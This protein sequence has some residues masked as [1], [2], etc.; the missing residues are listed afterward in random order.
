MEF[1]GRLASFPIGDILQWAHHDRRSGALVVRRSGTE[2]R[3]YLR[4]GDI[5]ACYSDDAAEYFGQYLLVRGLLREGE[6]IQALTH[7]QRRGGLLGRVLVDVGLL[8][9]EVMRAALR[10][11]VEDLVCELFLWKTGIFYFTTES[12]P[13]DQML[14]EPLPATALALEGS[15][16]ADEYRRIRRLFVHDHVVLVRGKRA[17][18]SPSPL[19]A[20]IVRSVDGERT[21]AELYSEVRGS[22]YRFLEA[23]YRLAVDGVLDIG[24]VHDLSDSDSTELR[25]ADLL[26]EQVA[27]EQSLYLKQHLS[28]PFEALERFVPIWVRSL[29]SA[30]ETRSSRDVRAFYEQIDGRRDLAELLAGVDRDERVRRMDR[31]VLQLRKGALALLPA[32]VETLETAAEAEERPEPARWWRRLR[33]AVSR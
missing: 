13:A 20:R 6:L 9:P 8:R 2:K 5:V 28:I 18:E 15:R 29:D 10:E 24:E 27:E 21:L 26:I 11:H 17:A 16:R 30:E 12:V 3:V 22:W 4:D 33:G 32:A 25:L 23:A 14:P 7:C 19:A 31:L 1:S